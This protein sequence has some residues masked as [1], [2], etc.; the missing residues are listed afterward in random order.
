MTDFTKDTTM[1]ADRIRQMEL[2]L[3]RIHGVHSARLQAENGEITEVHVVADPTRRPKWIVRDVV[4]TLFARYGVRVPYQKISVAG[5]CLL[6]TSD[7]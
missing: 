3:A 2:D 6:Y 5:S 1:Q 7:A 4:T